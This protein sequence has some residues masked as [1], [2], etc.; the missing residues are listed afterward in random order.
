MTISLQMIATPNSLELEP[1]LKRDTIDLFLVSFN[2]EQTVKTDEISI[3]FFINYFK[4]FLEMYY[5][6]D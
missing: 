4:G 6:F 1:K 3:K 2:I 5:Y